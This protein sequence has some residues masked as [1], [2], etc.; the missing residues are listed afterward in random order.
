M[1]KTTPTLPAPTVA[2][3]TTTRTFLLAAAACALGLAT[4]CALPPVGGFLL[5]RAVAAALVFPGLGQGRAVGTAVT[6]VLFSVTLTGGAYLAYR[7][8]GFGE[9]RVG[10]LVC[11]GLAGGPA[12][13]L[14]VLV[15]ARGHRLPFAPYAADAASWGMAVALLAGG[16]AMGGTRVLPA[17]GRERSRVFRPRAW[18]LPCLVAGWSVGW[19]LL[20]RERLPW[21]GWLPL[22]FDYFEQV[23]VV[24]ATVSA[25][26]L[27][28][29]LRRRLPVAGRP[30]RAFVLAWIALC[31]AP[32]VYAAVVAIDRGMREFLLAAPLSTGWVAEYA[33]DVTAVLVAVPVQTVLPPLVL[34]GVATGVQRMLPA[35]E[36][37]P[38]PVDPVRTDRR[39]GLVVAG[40]VVA[41]TYFCLAVTSRFPLLTGRMFDAGT[42]VTVRAVAMLAPP[43]PGLGRV[44]VVWSW[45][46]AAVF[47]VVATVLVYVAVRGQ[48]VRVFPVSCYPVLVG[49]LAL[50]AALAWNVGGLVAFAVAGGRP[51][52]IS[53]AV[54]AAEFT[55]FAAPVFGAVLFIVHSQVGVSR[56]ARVVELEGGQTWEQLAERYRAWKE[57]V[58]EHVPG[59]RE[60]GLIAARAAGGALVPA[61]VA[62]AVQGFA[63]LPDGGGFL[64][65][66]ALSAGVAAVDSLT[67][68]A[69]LVLLAGLVHVGLARVNL[70]E[71]RWSVW[72]TVWGMSV[73]AGGIAV[74]GTSVVTGGMSGTGG[75]GGEVGGVGVAAGLQLGL[76]AGPFAVAG[77]AVAVRRRVLLAGGVVLALVAAAPLVL[78]GGERVPLAVGT[79][80]WRERLPGLTLDVSY[81]RVTGAPDAARVNAALV[82]PVRAYVVEALR[83]HRGAP[84]ARVALTGGYA[85]VRNDANV[86]SV[87]YA[88]TGELGRAITY[89]RH[90]T[91]TLTV[92]DVFAPPAFTPTGRRRLADTLRPLIPEHHDPRTVSVD[93]DRLLV[94][95]APAAVELTFGRD[96]F[97]APCPPF[98]VRVPEERLPGLVI[99]RP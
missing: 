15:W 74:A 78:K 26:S 34:A 54:E 22:S 66:P 75:L 80:V 69:Y 24:L 90:A 43:D 67:G 16:L 65:F 83:R 70:R 89:D 8:S 10:L 9:S 88:L 68:L 55:V 99:R 28:G 48:L 76:L 84:G 38:G 6:L 25:A 41:L 63:G 11:W 31:V 92:R 21:L 77:V 18:V 57:Q 79:A 29:A 56:F 35:A 5:G 71:R 2:R 81:P 98:T 42:P 44:V 20:L 52:G 86:I 96:Y 73:L 14:A 82:A 95:L 3:T 85:L 64:V 17:A 94:N 62:G 4:L 49:A 40:A 87:R 46:I 19:S 30:G 13:V 32:V 12:G 93:S 45:V 1:A 59:R 50:A 51:A 7:W 60:R 47:A 72:L 53:P 58:R 36:K 33:T 37:P 39:W 97:C 61:V 23:A 27:E 91:R